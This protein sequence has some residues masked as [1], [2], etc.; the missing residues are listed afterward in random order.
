MARYKA[1]LVWQCGFN[2]AKHQ[3]EHFTTTVTAH[4][5][6]MY[7]LIILRSSATDKYTYILAPPQLSKRLIFCLYYQQ[8]PTLHIGVDNACKTYAYDTILLLYKA[9]LATRGKM[10]LVHT[11]A[12]AR[13][14]MCVCV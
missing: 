10:V 2:T 11:R 1:A 14:R 5:K 13:V 4:R 7:Q 8:R 3:K 9:P 12:R 6:I